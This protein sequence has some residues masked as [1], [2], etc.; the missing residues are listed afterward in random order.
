MARVAGA[1]T[2]KIVAAT[3]IAVPA[4]YTFSIWWKPDT[5]PSASTFADVISLGVA[6]GADVGFCWDH[7]SSPPHRGGWMHQDVTANFPV[8]TYATTFT[9]GV[10]HHCVGTY[11]GSSIRAYLNGALDATTGA[12]APNTTGTP[13][14]RVFGGDV[15]YNAPLGAACEAALWNAALNADEIAALAKGFS[16]AFF[17]PQSLLA[18][19]PLVRELFESKGNTLTNTGTTAGDHPRIIYPSRTIILPTPAVT[20]VTRSPGAGSIALT[21]I[22][23]TLNEASIR[24]P[25]A[26][27]VSITGYAP[28]LLRPV[29]VAVAAGAIAL[30]GLAPTLI[31][32]HIVQPGAGAIAL[33]GQTPAIIAGA[34]TFAPGAGAVSITGQAPTLNEQSI[35]TP[36]AGSVSLSGQ[37]PTLSENKIVPVGAYALALSGLA[38]QLTLQIVVPV[39]AG[40]LALAG[41]APSLRQDSVRTPAAGA[42]AITGYAPTLV[43]PN[44]IDVGTGTISFAGYAPTLTESGRVT[45]AFASADDGLVTQLTAANGAVTTLTAGDR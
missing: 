29:D 31:K 11:D 13:V 17:R 1:A 23:P 43:V 9:I 18:Y 16:P 15:G 38:P 45:G 37:A 41:L 3:S 25:A 22:A 32:N 28:T 7:G 30:T 44:L 36:A 20:G 34:N 35:R 10:W 4:N 40:A 5:L 26:G 33:S 19:A 39:A 14:F 8:A 2:D 42:V 6:G 12:S 21:G 24:T 27:A